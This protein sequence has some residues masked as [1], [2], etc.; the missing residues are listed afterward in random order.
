MTAITAALSLLFAY[1][2]LAPTQPV[3]AR[4]DYT[5]AARSSR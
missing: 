3:E 1:L 2:A 5:P 4:I